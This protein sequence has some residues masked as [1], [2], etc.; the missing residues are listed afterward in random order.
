MGTT[1]RAVS[2]TI[3]CQA[4]P[5]STSCPTTSG[6]DRAP[7][8]KNRWSVLSARPRAA[9]KRSRISPLAPPSSAPAPRPPGTAERRTISQG[10]TNARTASPMPWARAAPIR[11]RR[12][13]R[14]SVT[15]PPPS[16]PGGV[17]NS[18]DQVVDPD[19]GI[20][21]TKSRSIER[22]SDGT[23]RPDHPMSSKVRQLI[24]PAARGLARSRGA[25]QN[26]SG[27]GL[28][29]GRL[30]GRRAGDG[31]AHFGPILIGSRLPWLKAAAS[32]SA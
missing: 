4:T 9:W 6:D 23:S 10:G 28:L 22:M 18:P 1:A 29:S 31:H 2:I 14:R 12:R 20:G 26:P 25:P 13:P 27:A 21:L 32:R 7:M 8:L 11:M 30:P 3:P 17:R 24:T 16:E 15:T 5:A 19:P